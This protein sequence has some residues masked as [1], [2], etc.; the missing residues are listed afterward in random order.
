MARILIVDDEESIVYTFESFLADEGHEVLGAADFQEALGRLEAAEIDLVFTD[1]VLGGRTGIDLLGE[2]KARG[3]HCPVVVLTGYP[4][5]ETAAEAVRL[6]AFDYVSKPVVQETLLRLTA[7]ALAHKKT[8]DESERSRARMQCVFA[9]LGEGILTVDPGLTI[10]EVN[11]A[12]EAL[13]GVTRAQVGRNLAELELPGREGLLSVLRECLATAESVGERRIECR[14]EGAPPVVLA[15]SAYP[16]TDAA[17]GPVGAAL[18]TR[19]ESPRAVSRRGAG[20]Q[21]GLCGLVGA[22]PAMQRVYSLIESLAGMETTVLVTGESGTGKELVAEALHLLGPR[23]AGPLVK[24]NCSALSESLLESELFGHVRGAFTGA[25]SQR[26]GRFESAQGGTILLDEIGDVSPK[27]QLSL[28]RVLE[29]KQVERLGE[30]RSIPVDVRVIAATNGDLRE[31]IR[32]GQFREDLYYRLKV[33]EISLPPLRER[34][35]DIALLVRHFIGTLKGKLD[36]RITGLSADVESLF[37]CYSWPGNVR[38]LEN[39]LEHAFVLCPGETICLEHLPSQLRGGD[40]SAPAV[41]AFPDGDEARRIVVTLQK[42]AG[43]KAKAARV[44]GIDRK[45]LYRKMEKY[46]LPDEP[47]V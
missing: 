11:G 45:T 30:S 37:R 41:P 33:V 23:S 16:L 34:G 17:G 40:G 18:V 20:E 25:V 21:E 19:G 13:C 35:G 31:R 44:L 4:T 12:A 42:T 27:V 36:K 1:I 46:N 26:I 22:S 47:A 15:V 10:L 32:L 6:G 9:G 43:N 3:W 2:V 7:A 24:V 29:Q 5:L 14:D 39:S 8:L 28:L 38:E